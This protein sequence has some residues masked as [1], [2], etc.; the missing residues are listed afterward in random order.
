MII[1]EENINILPKK[2]Q[3]LVSSLLIDLE[4]INQCALYPISLEWIDVH[5]DSEDY[6]DYYGCYRLIYDNNQNIRET[7]GLEM[8]LLELDNAIC[9]I[10]NFIFDNG[11]KSQYVG[12]SDENSN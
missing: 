8:S 9:C 4:D 3:G 2:E 7:I 10:H 6:P 11:I 1:T 12:N 5:N